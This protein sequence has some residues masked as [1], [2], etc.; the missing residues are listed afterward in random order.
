VRAPWES[1][2]LLRPDAVIAWAREASSVEGLEPALERWF[3][4]P[5]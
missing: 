2:L 3:G 5:R 1:S 4:A